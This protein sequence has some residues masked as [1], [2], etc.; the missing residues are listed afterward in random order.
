MIFTNMDYDEIV[1]YICN[2]GIYT[3]NMVD[4]LCEI[5]EE[6]QRSLQELAATNEDLEEQLQDFRQWVTSLQGEIS[7]LNEGKNN[8]RI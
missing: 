5:I 1:R 6:N 3:G 2:N 8:E 4:R 7:D